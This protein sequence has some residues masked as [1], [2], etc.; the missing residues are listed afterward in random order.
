MKLQQVMSR[1]RKAL[2]DYHMIDEGDRI[3]IGGTS[4]SGTDTN[5][6]LLI[7]NVSLKVK[8]YESTEI[9][10]DPLVAELATDGGSR[11]ATSKS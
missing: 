10:V 8:K 2:D 6:R 3:A 4:V 11:G 7:D 1:V 9:V 5:L